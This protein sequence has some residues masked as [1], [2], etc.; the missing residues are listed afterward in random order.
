MET[1][2]AASFS[3]L[4][5]IS[6]FG[7]PPPPPASNRPPLA[8]GHAISQSQSIDSAMSLETNEDIHNNGDGSRVHTNGHARKQSGISADESEATYEM[9][10][11]EDDDDEDEV[12]ARNNKFAKSLN[13]E[14]SKKPVVHG[15]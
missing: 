8:N 7:P 14:E 11:R 13:S 10:E 2:A 9:E 1:D 15:E 4:T 3:R 12:Y 5:L 6:N